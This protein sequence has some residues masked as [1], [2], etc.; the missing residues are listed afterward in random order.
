MSKVFWYCTIQIWTGHWEGGHL[1]FEII[2][3][4]LG[5]ERVDGAFVVLDQ[6]GS[7]AVGARNVKP[8]ISKFQM[9]IR[10]ATAREQ[11]GIKK[12]KLADPILH[13]DLFELAEKEVKKIEFEN[14]SLGEYY[15][16]LKIYDRASIINDII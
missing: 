16:L 8:V 12:F 15:K 9:K 14:E 10:N 1:D 5:R 2:H 13:K 11:S 6:I 7:G 4:C 3:H